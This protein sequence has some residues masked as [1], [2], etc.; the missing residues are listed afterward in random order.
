MQERYPSRREDC[1]PIPLPCT[2]V[3]DIDRI[4]GRGER[5]RFITEA[6]QAKLTERMLAIA[7]RA[8]GAFADVD[9]PGWETSES[10]TAWVR[11]QRA[12]PD[13]AREPKIEE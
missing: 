8:A 12:E 5:E 6:V 1:V 4:V 7:D 11:Q 2:L 13:A 3:E 9:I 10:T